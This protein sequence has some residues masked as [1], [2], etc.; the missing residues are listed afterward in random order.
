VVCFRNDALNKHTATLLQYLGFVSVEDL[1]ILIMNKGLER[2]D[3]G[4][5][6]RLF[7]QD[8]AHQVCVSWLART[9]NNSRVYISFVLSC[10]RLSAP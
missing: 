8:V 5:L 9:S 1:M 10:C 7:T 3:P 6:S 4:F 2:S